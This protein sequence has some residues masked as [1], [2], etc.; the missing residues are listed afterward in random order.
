MYLADMMIDTYV[1]ESALLRSR[2]LAMHEQTGAGDMT[3]VLL[4]DGMA[5]I[6]LP[7]AQCAGCRC[8]PG[9]LDL[10]RR[11][12]SAEPVDAIDLPPADRPAAVT[13]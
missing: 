5:H 3:A 11:L 12:A 2:K 10:V 6:K 7:R 8:S 1:M 13:N 4:G 9:A